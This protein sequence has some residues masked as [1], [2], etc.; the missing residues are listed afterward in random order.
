M[1]SKDYKVN[2][3]IKITAFFWIFTKII[4][5]KLWFSNRLFPLIPISNF[6]DNFPHW[7]HSSLFYLGILS[8]FCILILPL[9][10]LIIAFTLFFEILSCLLDMNRWQPYEYHFILIFCLALFIKEQKYIQNYF[11]F[12]L[13][14]IYANSGL[15][16]LNGGFLYY[17]WEK[18]IL[19]KFLGFEIQRTTNT[20]IYY[21]GLFVGLFEFICA[22]CLI[23]LKNKKITAILL[24][25][26]HVF[27]IVMLSPIGI[28]YNTVVIPWNLAIISFLIVLYFT[29]QNQ[30]F[31]F[32]ELINGYQFIFFIVIGLLPLFN[33]FGMYDNY[34]SF[35]LYSGNLTKMYIC[36]D[37]SKEIKHFE[38]YLSKNKSTIDCQNLISIS[39][40]SHKELNTLPYP[41]KRVYF[42]IRDKWIMQ[43]PTISANFYLVNY[44]YHKEN[45]VL[46]EK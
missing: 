14:I 2:Y 11:I 15:H 13:V 1:F 44:P 29:N 19:Q 7:F 18:T 41:E 39:N 6:F 17:V 23:F 22:I 16:K 21:S 3:L 42:K 4:S 43:N 34:L 37:N 33:F 25:A 10:R 28:N 8:M 26:M 31:R 27:I 32:K 20:L 45:W 36:S 38:P 5:Y 40:W 46:M 12:L 9:N 30:K 35:N 24:I